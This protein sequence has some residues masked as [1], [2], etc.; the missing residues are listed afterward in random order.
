[1]REMGDTNAE[2]QPTLGAPTRRTVLAAT[3]ATVA[4]AGGLAGTA[5]A[6]ET[7]T[8]VITVPQDW[9][10]QNL[11]GFL[12]RFGDSGGDGS[13]SGTDAVGQTG[14]DGDAGDGGTADGSEGEDGG[15][16]GGAT[17]DEGSDGG[18]TT[19]GDETGAATEGGGDGGIDDGTDDGSGSTDDG[20][21]GGTDD[22]ADVETAG[23]NSVKTDVAAEDVP[24]CDFQD[25]PPDTVTRYTVRLVDRKEGDSDARNV[26]L[27]VGSD[28]EIDTGTEQ[29]INTFERCDDEHAGVELE[30][31]EGGAGGGG[32]G[33]G[34]DA[35]PAVQVEDEERPTTGEGPGGG[36]ETPASGPGLGV[37]G[38]LAGLAG[39]S[40]L[41]A[42]YR[43]E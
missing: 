7:A 1:M 9:Q 24:D 31:V 39:L 26:R 2:R 29:L 10:D 16:D 5:V 14:T 12:I 23:D 3:A 37:L 40:G 38:A 27:Y 28:T 17:A 13:G 30:P 11:A 6:Q 19:G 33:G 42:R 43:D 32:S 21:N 8:G 20:D 4:G 36:G 25:W 34:D 15:G 18:A 41:L 22:E 35:G